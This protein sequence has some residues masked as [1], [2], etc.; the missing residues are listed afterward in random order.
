[1]E[2]AYDKIAMEIASANITEESF[3]RISTMN[4]QEQFVENLAHQYGLFFEALKH[5]LI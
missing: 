2:Q 3:A 1:M 4:E 5:Q